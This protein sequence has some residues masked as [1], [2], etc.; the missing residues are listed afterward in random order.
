MMEESFAILP[1]PL[2]TRRVA[3]FWIIVPFFPSCFVKV[4]VWWDDRTVASSAEMIAQ[5]IA[6]PC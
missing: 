2:L 3:V 4:S 1:T 5:V 6:S